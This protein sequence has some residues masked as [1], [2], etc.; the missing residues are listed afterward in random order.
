MRMKVLTCLAVAAGVVGVASLALAQETSPNGPGKANKFQ[1]TL[2]TAYQSCTT[3]AGSNSTVTLPLPACDAV[4]SDAAC[5]FLDSTDTADSVAEKGSGKVKATV[6]GATIKISAQLKGLNAG[7]EGKTLN[8]V[9]TARVTSEDCTTPPCTV[10]D[11]ATKDF[12]TGC[13]CGPVAGGACSCSS[14]VG[15]GVLAGGKDTNIQLLGTAALDGSV[16]A[17]E[18]GV[19]IP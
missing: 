4:R 7:C 11:A 2:V 12:P 16:H 3:L 14:V 15:P 13:A 19:F 5:G 8:M 9:S 18:G 1:S 6:S 10:A 17:F